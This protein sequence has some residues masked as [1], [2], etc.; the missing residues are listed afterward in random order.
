MGVYMKLFGILLMFLIMLG[1]LAFPVLAADVSGTGSLW[2]NG[3]G[4]ASVSGDG[5]STMTGRGFVR[6]DSGNSFAHGNGIKRTR[7]DSTW[8][9]GKGFV[10]VTG[11]DIAMTGRAQGQIKAQGTGSATLSG[12][13]WYW[14]WK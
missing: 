7:G 5:V 6:V 2:A 3:R 9:L 12:K 14:A 11:D 1:L 10:T 4:R 8:Y 13:G